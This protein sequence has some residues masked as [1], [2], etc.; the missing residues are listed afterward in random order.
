MEKKI[1]E[2]PKAMIVEIDDRCMQGNQGST[3]IDDPQ[4]VEVEF[5]DDFGKDFP[6]K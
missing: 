4:S 5:S 6:E 2:Q 3:P 1:Y